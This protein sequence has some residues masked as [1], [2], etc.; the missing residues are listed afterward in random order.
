VKDKVRE[1]NG[2]EVFTPEDMMLLLKESGNTVTMKVVPANSEMTTHENVSPC[3]L[4]F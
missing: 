3:C 4:W 2:T 1:V